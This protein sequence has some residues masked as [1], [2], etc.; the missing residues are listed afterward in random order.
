MPLSVRK[1][2][3]CFNISR[4]WHKG[5]CFCCSTGARIPVDFVPEAQT[6]FCQ[7]FGK[8]QPHNGVT[9]VKSSSGSIG[10]KPNGIRPLPTSVAPVGLYRSFRLGNATSKSA[11]ELSKAAIHA[12]S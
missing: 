9:F 4:N 3:T 2:F 10:A 8:P 12:V 1:V 5:Q 11:V 7:I 6:V